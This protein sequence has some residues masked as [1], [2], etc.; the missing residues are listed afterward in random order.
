MANMINFIDRSPIGS[1]KK[2]QE[3]YLIAS[4]RVARTGVQIYLAHEIGDA[5]IQAGFKPD[6]V[7][8][9][10]RPESAVFDKAAMNTLSRVPVTLNHPSESVTAEN[11]KDLAVGEVGD[12]VM[13][14][15]EWIVV[16]PMIKDAAAL[17][18]ASTTHKEISMGYA[19]NLV[20]AKDKSIADFDMVDIRFNHLALVEK[21]RAG[22]QARIGDA[23]WGASPQTVEDNEMTVELKTVVLGDKAVSVEAK[24][25]DTVAAILK[26]HAA[27]VA[28]K[29][30]EIGELKA[31]LATAE[32]KVLSDEAV[33]KLVD[34]RVEAQTKREAVKAAFGDEAVKDAS[35]AEIAGMFKVI[36]K[37]VDDSARRALADKKPVVNDAQAAEDRILA[38]QRKFLNLEAK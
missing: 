15:G 14:D 16:N 13:R 38:A 9:V 31:K 25:A 27:I 24:D 5:A 12:T 35:D 19:A 7:V 10:N 17:L 37:T 3:G 21:G 23:Q 33:A 20:E 36:D 8:R 22:S 6:A 26:D 28:D 18:A 4:S 32:A 30:T 2:T 11:W 1:I 29:D 34:A